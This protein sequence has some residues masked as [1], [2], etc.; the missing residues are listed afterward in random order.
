MWLCRWCMYLC[1]L[2]VRPNF[3]AQYYRQKK[4]ETTVNSRYR[5]AQAATR[6]YSISSRRKESKESTSRSSA[7]VKLTHYGVSASL[8]SSPSGEESRSNKHLAI[9]HGGSRS[10]SAGQTRR[11][12]D[13]DSTTTFFRS[14]TC[15]RPTPS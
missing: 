6:G 10:R 11:C 7:W 13:L 14:Q 3:E 15:T 2:K 9:P 8:D 5:G 4:G 1:A 12:N